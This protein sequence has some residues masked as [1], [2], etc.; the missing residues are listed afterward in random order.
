MNYDLFDTIINQ[1]FK[2]ILENFEKNNIYQN[3]IFEKLVLYELKKE[4]EINDF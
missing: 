2:I 1:N 4:I 3:E